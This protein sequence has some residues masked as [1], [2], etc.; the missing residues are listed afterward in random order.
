ML[1]D[2]R[3][4][5]DGERIEADLCIIGC[6]PAGITIARELARPGRR[7][8][9]L[10]SG[11]PDRNAEADRLGAGESV[12]EPYPDLR[13]PRA[14]GIGGTSLHWP[15]LTSGGDE[16]WIA[17]PLDPLDFEQRPWIE[18]SGW[19]VTSAEMEPYYR[20]AQEVA[21]LGPYA[22]SATDWSTHDRRPMDLPADTVVTNVFQR[23]EHRFTRYRDD[24]ARSEDIR[25]IHDTTVLEMRTDRE[26][27]AVSEVFAA[28][29]GDRRLTVAA[30]RFVVAT[31]GIENARLLLAS[32]S[33][34][35]AGLGNQ[36]DLVGRFFMERLSARGG[37]LIPAGPD[38]V[39]AAGLYASHQ[40]DGTRVQGVLSLAPDVVRR[41]RLRNATFWVR[42]RV[43]PTTAPGIQSAL[44]MYRLAQRHPLALRAFPGHVL[45]V[46]KDLP[47]IA[48]T[49]VY[50]A[51]HRVSAADE[52]FQLGVQAEQAPNPESR[53]TLGNGHDRF[54]SPVARLD[55][56]PTAEDRDSIRR[57]VEILDG[58]LRSAGIGRVIHRFGTE[59]E[60]AMFIGNWH[61]MGTTRM[62][63]DPRRGVVDPSGRVHS[64]S[65]LY[66]AGSSVF[67]TSGFA[68]PTLTVTALALRLADAL[69]DET[70][71]DVAA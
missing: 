51:T 28:T 38:V 16:G 26:T 56:R 25:V 24:L 34:R 6:G 66:I 59:R 60:P 17:R 21:G 70:A 8:I 44:T 41:E 3:S 32:R 35:P 9:V 29:N 10:E 40:V 18:H 46:A 65:N 22:Y 30:R 36:H 33:D 45:S 55:W 71:A 49:G 7:L 39:R 11:S 1:I 61:H 54:G 52:V 37:V 68:N 14:R 53:V 64:L 19:P 23:G 15:M 47:E 43:R 31:G 2:G 58:A 57:T 48:R 63:A 5:P 4:L 13:V 20:R 69:R 12:G 62:D 27:N 50:Y 42:E 67:P